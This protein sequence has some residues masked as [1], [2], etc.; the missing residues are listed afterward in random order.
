MTP[1]RTPILDAFRRELKALM[2][3]MAKT[4]NIV[5]ATATVSSPFKYI[6]VFMCVAQS[7][8]RRRKWLSGQALRPDFAPVLSDP[9]RMC[10]YRKSGLSV[11]KE[12]ESTL[13]VYTIQLTFPLPNRGLA[14]ASAFQGGP[15]EP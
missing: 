1:C 3:S 5:S 10:V 2:R 12:A 8:A 4:R 15:A 11:G 13:N 6:T 7:A 9:V 14:S